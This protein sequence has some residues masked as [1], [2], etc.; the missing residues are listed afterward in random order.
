MGRQNGTPAQNGVPKWPK[1]P[2]EP[3]MQGGQVARPFS[4][5]EALTYSPWTSIGTFDSSKLAALSDRSSSHFRHFGEAPRANSLSSD[6]LPVPS[7]GSPA[8][9]ITDLASAQNFDALNQRVL[10]QPHNPDIQ[11]VF[12]QVQHMISQRNG[13]TE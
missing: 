4:L 9:S 6:I 11:Q 10:S 1:V 3:L 12:R 13:S 7:I 2:A 5:L 8:P